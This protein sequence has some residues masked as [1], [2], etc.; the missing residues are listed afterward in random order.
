MR[1]A[2][3]RPEVFFQKFRHDRENLFFGDFSDKFSTASLI[4]RKEKE[5]SRR[6]RAVRCTSEQIIRKR[7]FESGLEEKRESKEK[8]F[9]PLKMDPP[10][11]AGE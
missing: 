2:R 5:E 1:A 3:P 4:V 11:K 10:N 6:V 9:A 7:T 8:V